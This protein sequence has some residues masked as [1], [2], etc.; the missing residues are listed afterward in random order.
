MF[1]SAKLLSQSSEGKL[2]PSYDFFFS[3]MVKIIKY[4]LNA[5][6][7][8]LIFQGRNIHLESLPGVKTDQYDQFLLLG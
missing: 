8:L 3:I 1:T 2:Y 5:K 7:L 4:N 6:Q